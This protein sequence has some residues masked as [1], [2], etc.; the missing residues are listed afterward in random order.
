FDGAVL[1]EVVSPADERPL[2]ELELVFSSSKGGGPLRFLVSGFDPSALPQL[3]VKDYPKGLYMPMGIG[4]PPFFQGYADLQK[5]PPDQSP[6]FSLL[7]DADGRWVD[8]HSFAI[9]GPVLHRDEHDPS[10]LHLYLLSYE[11]HTLIGHFVI[12]TRG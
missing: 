7:L 5:N 12:P 10:L 9:D 4:V 2:A 6:Y 3:P 11:R 1:R 8:H